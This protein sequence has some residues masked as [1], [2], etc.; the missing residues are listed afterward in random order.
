MNSKQIIGLI[1]SIIVLIGMFLPIIST[2]SGAITT[3]MLLLTAAGLGTVVF[4]ATFIH[5]LDV[6][7]NI[8][9]LRNVSVI[10][11]LLESTGAITIAIGL[12]TIMV[13][14]IMPSIDR[15]VSS[16]YGK[17]RKSRISQS[18]I[19]SKP[20]AQKSNYTS[21][22]RRRSSRGQSI[23]NSRSANR[24]KSGKSNRSPAAK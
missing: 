14:A 22:T 2:P 19:H 1:G 24:T 10:A 23:F 6:L 3:Y 16:R 12:A 13:A 4:Y 11:I 5:M 21:S 17:R 8:D 7:G 18:N 9:D 15:P 20:T